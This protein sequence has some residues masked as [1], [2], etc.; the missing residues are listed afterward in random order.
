MSLHKTTVPFEKKLKA[1]TTYLTTDNSLRKVAKDIGIPFK[2]LWFW[3]K[4]Y[5]EGG[6]EG[7][8]KKRVH[9]KRIP[10]ALETKVMFLK[11]Q[12]P[13]LSIGKA[14]QLLKKQGITLSLRKIWQTWKRYGLSK[15]P[16]HSPLSPFC[17]ATPE[18]DDGIRRAKALI[19]EGNLKA[20]AKILN[21]LPCLPKDLVIKE[22]PEKF[23][24][25]RR[26][27]ERLYLEYAEI[28]FP[29]FR[30]K[31]RQLA[32]ILEKKGRIYSSIIANFM[33]MVALG[34]IRKPKEK[35]AVLNSLAKKMHHVKDKT[36]LF[37]FYSDKAAIYC[38]LLQVSKALDAIKTCRRLLYRLRLPFYWYEFGTLLTSLSKY[39]EAYSFH[40]LALKHEKDRE[41]VSQ[42]AL[43]IALFGHGLA[44]EYKKC[45]KMLSKAAIIKNKTGY[46]SEY[47][48]A[49]ACV[50]FG[51]GNL[52]QATKFFLESLKK[53]SKGELCNLI[54]GTSSGLASV[55]MALDKKEEATMH[56]KKYL[57]LMKKYGLLKA[58]LVLK[59][60]LGSKE[61]I[62]R[63]LLLMPTF[64]L[65][66]LLERANETLKIGDYR[67]AFNYAQRQRLL[68]LFHRWIVF[69]PK[70]VVHLLERGKQTGLPKAILKF[71]VFNQNI[72]VYYIRFLGNVITSKGPSYV[73]TKLSPLEKAFLIHLALRAGSPGKSIPVS[74]LYQNFWTHNSG[75]SNLLL[76][77]L[78]RL[79]KKLKMPGHFLSISSTYG[80]PRLINRSVY[81]TTDYSEFDTLLTQVK[82]LERAGEWRFAMSDY[83]RAFRLIRG[84]PFKKMYDNWSEGVR[85]AI[86]N[87]LE[88]AAIHFAQGCLEHNNKKDAKKILKKVS[89]IIP[90]SREVSKM[91][92]EL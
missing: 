7:L 48:L 9:K 74:D 50:S 60:L 25:P 92:V 30:R 1:V 55:A 91:S 29:E 33:E 20:A 80:E 71:P 76:H 73:R 67:K 53:V 49:Q 59:H 87:K 12:N 65:L 85:E 58:V 66:N 32:K 23:L 52:A 81:I 31:A 19:C 34:W 6:K 11:E 28:P 40:K 17:A 56:L 10:K 26:R 24:S 36:L 72:P 57:P 86:L 35:M 18:T 90:D 46:S 88:D 42:F 15:R 51:E 78:V 37:L 70:P 45:K 38:D 5:K 63:E 2:T 84:A 27:L 62:F 89:T 14:Q 77:F 43:I 47:S 44:G 69:F 68:G 39:K 64:C 4:Q 82:S 54:Y 16:V 79:K 41:I 3:V 61:P 22:I 8:K 13:S 75:S 83:I 21:D